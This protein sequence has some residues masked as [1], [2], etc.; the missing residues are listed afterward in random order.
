MFLIFIFILSGFAYKI[1]AVPFHFWCPDVYEGAPIPVTAFLSIGPKAAG[2]AVMIRFFYT[3]FTH[4]HLGA[5]IPIGI[6]DW[7][8]LLSVISAL[9]MTLGNLAAIPQT[10]IKRLLAY[11]SIAHAGYIL[12]GLVS[13]SIQGFK[14]M[15]FYLIVYLFMNF[16]AFIILMVIHNYNGSEDIEGFKGLGWNAPFLAAS[17]TIFLFCLTGIP[18]FAGFIGKFYLFAALINKELYWLAIV[19]ILNSVISLYYYARIIKA[20]Y[21]DAPLESSIVPV[22]LVQKILIM[23]LAIPTILFGIYWTPIFNFTQS[24]LRLVLG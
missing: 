22:T 8:F 19:G 14:A 24:S 12:M 18:P 9:T 21:V 11:S 17:M 2:F 20:M 16:G 7:P 1:A 10:N 6:T 4:G 15:L 3:V 13:L 5:L 23:L